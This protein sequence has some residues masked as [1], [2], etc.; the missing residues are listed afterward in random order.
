[1]T[2]CCANLSPERNRPV[3]ETKALGAEHL[4]ALTRV[5]ELDHFIL[6]SSVTTLIGNVGQANYVAANGYLEGLARRRRM[7]GLPALA[8]AFGPI[9]DVGVLAARSTLGDRL[10]KRLGDTAMSAREALR[11]VEAYIVGDRQA[12]ENSCVVIAE[13]DWSVVSKLKITRSSLFAPVRNSRRNSPIPDEA[14]GQDLAAVLAG[15]SEAEAEA[16]VFG[17]VAEE[18][19][20]AL[21]IPLSGV[22]RDMVLRDA[23]LDSLMAV[24][25]GMSLEKRTGLEVTLNG[26]SETATI[27]DLAGKLLSRA[28]RTDAAEEKPPSDVNLRQLAS[29]HLAAS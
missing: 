22:S 15:K 9:G 1:M 6:F 29:R 25:L 16:I 21:Q 2:R 17:M 23:G 10:A 24:E 19:A 14:A 7:D 27:G 8:V 20:T 18:L 4:D 26:L 13:F 5:D 11:H 3:V 28:R 12:V